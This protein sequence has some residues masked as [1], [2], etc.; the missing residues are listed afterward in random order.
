ML[1]VPIEADEWELLAALLEAGRITEQELI[2]PEAIA[3]ATIEVVQE[4]AAKWT[5]L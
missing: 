2:S 3:R 5:A 4:W 1:R